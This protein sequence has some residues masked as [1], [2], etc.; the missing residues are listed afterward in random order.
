MAIESQPFNFGGIEGNFPG[1]KPRYAVLP[2]PYDLT[3][4]YGSGMRNGP[5]AIIEA[6]THMELYD[7]ELGCEHFASGI[8]TLRMLESTTF[9]P[10]RMIERIEGAV[11]GIVK[12][13]VIPV[14]LGGEHSITLGAVR[15]LKKKYKNLSVL[16]FDAHADMR[17]EYQESPFNHACVGRRISEIC[18]IAQIGIRSLSIEEAGFLKSAAKSKKY[19]ILTCYASAIKKK[20]VK[21]ALKRVLKTLT[22]DVFITIDL[23]VFD[24]SI[25]PSTGTPEPGGLVWHEVLDVLRGVIERKNIRGFDV[26]ELAPQ[27]GNPAPDFMAAKLVYKIMGYVNARLD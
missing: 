9:G 1:G 8:E 25:M 11:T 15:A 6:S 20:G 7:E 5:R 2:V 21:D 13:G 24:P 27:P 16:Q 17:D 23:D 19:G 4:S 18:P 12:R 3:A 26:V 10:E 14:M 22:K